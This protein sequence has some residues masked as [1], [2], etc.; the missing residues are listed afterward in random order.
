MKQSFYYLFDDICSKITCHSRRHLTRLN[1]QG[2]FVSHSVLLQTVT[3]LLGRTS[4]FAQSHWSPPTPNNHHVSTIF[5]LTLPSHSFICQ[6]PANE[7]RPAA[8]VL[9]VDVSH[10]IGYVRRAAVVRAIFE[11]KEE[12]RKAPYIRLGNPLL[13]PNPRHTIYKSEQSVTLC[14]WWQTHLKVTAYDNYGSW[15]ASCRRLFLMCSLC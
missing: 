3:P 9:N 1:W 12:R 10:F 8:S 14:F 2:P 7:G 5:Q 6:V 15:K 4:Q 11:L 13:C